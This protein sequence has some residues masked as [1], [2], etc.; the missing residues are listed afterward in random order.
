MP[1]DNLRDALLL[2]VREHGFDQIQRCLNEIELLEHTHR[3]V[4]RK[5]T[6]ADEA[7]AKRSPR[8]SRPK[9]TATQYV[10]KLELSPEKVASVA[11]LAKRFDVKAFLPSF[12]DIRH[13]CDIYGVDTPA[14]R[15]RVSAIPRVFKRIA[16]LEAADIQRIIDEGHFSGPSRLGPIADAIRR[17]GRVAAAEDATRNDSM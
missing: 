2:M 15:T 8:R 16:T 1:Q 14:S 5:P 17:N 12:G 9:S 10:A 7:P 3:P 11:E 13:F 4:V 6:K